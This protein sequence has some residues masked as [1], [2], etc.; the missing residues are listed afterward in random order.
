MSNIS[1][2]R[3]ANLVWTIWGDFGGVDGTH[4]EV[5]IEKKKKKVKNW[6]QSKDS[7]PRRVCFNFR[8]DLRVLGP[9]S[10]KTT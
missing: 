9:R 4:E 10:R 1:S 5:K 6:E 3:N 7:K 8:I 2:V